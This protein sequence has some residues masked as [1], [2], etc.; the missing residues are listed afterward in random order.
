MTRPFAA[1]AFVALV[2]APEPPGRAV[3]PSHRTV[4]LRPAGPFDQRCSAHAPVCVQVGAGVSETASV[5]AIGAAEQAF[6]TLDALK[7][8]RPLYDGKLGGD[9]R[10]DVYLD[11]TATEARVLGDVGGRHS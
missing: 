9:A 11:A 10:L 6:A 7:L 2:I 5:A 8:P 4:G 3:E 1:S